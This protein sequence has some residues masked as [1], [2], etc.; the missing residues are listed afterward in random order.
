VTIPIAPTAARGLVAGDHAVG[1]VQG[2]SGGV[3][4]PTGCIAAATSPIAAD[5]LAAGHVPRGADGHVWGNFFDGQNW[6]W[7]DQ[8][9]PGTTRAAAGAGTL[10]YSDRGIQRLYAFVCGAD[11]QIMAPG[12]SGFRIDRMRTTTSPGESR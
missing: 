8:G 11:G 4:A 6:Y 9:A 3:Q 2:A 10:T 5:A 12:T 1:N 7:A